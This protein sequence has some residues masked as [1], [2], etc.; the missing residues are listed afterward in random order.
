MEK[1][2][3]NTIATDYGEYH[4]YINRVN[5]AKPFT[6]FLHGGPGLNCFAERQDLG[7]IFHKHLNFIWFDHL[8]C[9]ESKA[10]SSDKLG[11]DNQVR[12]II[13]VTRK[14]TDNPVDVIGH[15]LGAQLT[16]DLIRLDRN[17]VRRVVWYSPVLSV[18]GVFKRVLRRSADEGQID[19]AALSTELRAAYEEILQTSDDKFGQKEVMTALQLIAQMRDFQQLYWHDKNALIRYSEHMKDRPMAVD[20]FVKMSTDYFERGILPIPSYENIPVFMLHSDNDGI[21]PWETNGAEILKS[22]PHAETR[23]IENAYHW[24]H[25][26]KPRECAEATV[27]FLR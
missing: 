9:A 3:K 26:E 17:F 2:D 8:G 21:T 7:P 1:I 24:I 22:I 18:Q 6:I 19:L 13:A 15:C 10:H 5:A 14:I 27:E 11:H 25:L 16:H 23:L 12:D 20:V 4:V